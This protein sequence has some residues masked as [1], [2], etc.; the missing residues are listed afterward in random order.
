VQPPFTNPLAPYQKNK[1]RINGEKCVLPEECG[2]HLRRGDELLDADPLVGGVCEVWGHPVASRG[3]GHH[4]ERG[5]SVVHARARAAAHRVDEG[6]VESEAPYRRPVGGD[7]PR[8]RGA[9]VGVRLPPVQ[10]KLDIVEAVL[11]KVGFYLIPYVVGV[12]AWDEADVHVRLR[13]GRVD[14]VGGW[15]DVTGL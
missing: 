5:G 4:P 10:L 9:P 15:A 11:L 14:G 12:H 2:A 6:L 8:V 3:G 7:Y 1:S 13:P